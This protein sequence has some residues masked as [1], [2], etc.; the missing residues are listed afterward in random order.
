MKHDYSHGEVFSIGLQALVR[1]TTGLG[2]ADQWTCSIRITGPRPVVRWTWSGDPLGRIFA[3]SKWR[4]FLRS[5][6][7]DLVQWTNHGSTGLTTGPLVCRTESSCGPS[8][9]EGFFL[10]VCT[11]GPH[12][13]LF[14]S[15]LTSHLDKTISIGFLVYGTPYLSS[16]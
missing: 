6:P 16:I 3:N 5:G 15:V 11:G 1:W 7:V 13:R 14:P 4:S 12:C 2:P 8:A 10:W 9:I